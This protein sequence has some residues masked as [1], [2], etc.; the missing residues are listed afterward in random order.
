MGGKCLLQRGL[1][2]LIA[3]CTRLHPLLHVGLILWRRR[4]GGFY[5]WTCTHP[6]PKCCATGRWERNKLCPLRERVKNF[7]RG[8]SPLDLGG[9]MDGEHRC[10]RCGNAHVASACRQEGSCRVLCDSDAAGL[11]LCGVRGCWGSSLSPLGPAEVSSAVPFLEAFFLAGTPGRV[12][13]NNVLKK[14]KFKNMD[15]QMLGFTPGFLAIPAPR[16]VGKRAR[17]RAVLQSWRSLARSL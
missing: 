1:L 5:L 10:A 6:L 15:A 12:Q 11:P 9:Q 17:C 7:W 16:L 4:S 14:Q 13:W 8:G 2:S 3:C